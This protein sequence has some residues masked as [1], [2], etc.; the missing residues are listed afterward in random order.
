LVYSFKGLT[1]NL[2]SIVPSEYV[3][4]EKKQNEI[5]LTV[6]FKEAENLSVT[7]LDISGKLIHNHTALF[8]AKDVY[9]Y[10]TIGLSKGVY[11]VR[12]NT[13]AGT[14]NQVFKFVID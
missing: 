11:F 12:V 1:A 4:F 8:S 10:S 9:H 2:N 3:Y 13:T 14:N 6:D 7:L 5:E